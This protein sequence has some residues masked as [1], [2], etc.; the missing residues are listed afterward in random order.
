MHDMEMGE[1]P[2][3]KRYTING[4]PIGQIKDLLDAVLNSRDE[5]VFPNWAAN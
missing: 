3:M 2:G 5:G 4:G 1:I